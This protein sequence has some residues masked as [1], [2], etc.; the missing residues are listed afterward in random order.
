MAVAEGGG[1]ALS[2]RSGWAIGFTSMAAMALSYVDRQSLAVLAPTVTKALGIS[3]AQYGWLGSAFAI[4]YLVAGPAAGVLVDTYGA[5][6]SLPWAIAV[7]SVVAALHAVVPGFG[8]LFGLRLALGVAESPSFPAAAQIVQRALPAADRPRGMS[9]LFVGMSVGGMI[10]PLIAIG[11]ASRF[12]WRVAFLGTAALAVL[13]LPVWRAVT[14]GADARA[15]LD[16]PSAAGARGRLA[17]AAVH[18]AMRRGL[19]GL[20]AVVPASA[21]MMAWEAKFYV[22]EA[23][24]TQGELAGYLMTSAV[25]YDAGAVLFGDLASRRARARGDGSPH[26]LL[27]AVGA[28]LAACGMTV[29][30]FAHVPAV[31]LAGMALG[32]TGRGAIVTLANSDTLARMPQRAVAAAGGVIAS[33]QSLGAVVLNPMIGAVVQKHGYAGVVIA[34]SAWTVPLAI[35]WLAWPPPAPEA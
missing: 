7:W 35:A 12:S 16:A 20:L 1:V 10:A 5:R 31:A 18:P 23:H 21:F 4:A 28:S 6:R 29:L 15:A 27:Y 17:D 32:A 9:T 8:V 2:R 34:I 26:R 25:L 30:A 11:L 14:G 33:V 24:L 19:V 13:W 3:D 22:R